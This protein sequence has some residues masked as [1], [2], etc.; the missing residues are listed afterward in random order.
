L[1]FALKTKPADNPLCFVGPRRLALSAWIQ[2]VPFGM[3]L[4]DLLRPASIVEL[5]TRNGISYCAFCQAVERL[6]IVAECVAVDSWKGDA[7]TGAYGPSVLAELRLHHDPLYGGFSRLQQGTFDDAARDFAPRSID[8]LHI[9]GLHTYEAVQHDFE[10]WLPKMSPRGVV[11]LHDI[12]ER[13][14]DFGVWRFWER[15]SARHPS[16]AFF[17][18]HGLG[19]L[20]VGRELPEAVTDLLQLSEERAAEVRGFFRR[21]GTAV[22]LRLAADFA[23]RLPSRVADTALRLT[24]KLSAGSSPGA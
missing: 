2:H 17:H 9:D 21:R 12:A 23:L 11:L 7:H 10:T 1:G 15:A 5:G 4:V 16:F 18:G 14:R 19:V 8:L 20:G 3:Y 22:V 6:G 13:D 24:R